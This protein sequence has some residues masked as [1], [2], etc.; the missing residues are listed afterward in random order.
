M[1]GTGRA[2]RETFFMRYDGKNIEYIERPKHVIQ[3][4]EIWMCEINANGGSVQS[5]YR[6]V[7]VVS[8]N[9]NNKY[10]NTLNVM[11]MTSKIKRTDLPCHVQVADY[12]GCG[13]NAPSMILVEQLTTVN[14]DSL[15]RRIGRIDDV[16]TLQKICAGMRAQFPLLA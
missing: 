14:K 16:E 13:L 12:V 2:K 4:G 15:V 7:F 11:P 8:N 10:S 9:A 5:G 6:P 1:E 3:C